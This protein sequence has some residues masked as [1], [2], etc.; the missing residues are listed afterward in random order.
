MTSTTSPAESSGP[1][2]LKTDSRGRVCMPAQKREALLDEFEK[3][4]LSG[5]KFAALAGIKYSTFACWAQK[6]RHK[7]NASPAASKRAPKAQPV[8]WLEAVVQEACEPTGAKGASLL[9]HLP[10]GIRAE[11]ASTGAVSLAAAL[12]RALDKPC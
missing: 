11:L 4:G 12:I 6:R 8:A 1:L 3:S 10:G 9:L 7:E 2:I 5:A